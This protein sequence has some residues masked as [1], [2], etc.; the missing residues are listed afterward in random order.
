MSEIQEN[1]ISESENNENTKV[2][3]EFQGEDEEERENVP[4]ASTAAEDVEKM[5]HEGVEEIVSNEN[6][7]GF[8]GII[9]GFDTDTKPTLTNVS[10]ENIS[11]VVEEDPGFQSKPTDSVSLKSP[12]AVWMVEKNVSPKVMNTI[13]WKDIKRT[14]C[15]FGGILFLLLSLNC[16]PLISVVTTFAL[17]FLCVCF[18][19]HI[20]MTVF[21]VVQKT[22]AE[23]PFKNL[24]EQNIEIPE[25]VVSQLST[26]ICKFINAEI[27]CCQRL[28]LIENL[29]ES[30]KF[31]ITLWLVSYVS[32]WFSLLTMIIL[33]V[34]TLFTVPKLYEEKQTEIDRCFCVVK[35]KLCDVTK[36]LE[37][38]VPEKF[39][40]YLC[41]DKKE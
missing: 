36:Q 15:I 35:G 34:I 37:Q 11:S 4:T 18:L 30:V 21:N 8:R 3:D 39:K 10:T 38:K 22:T 31:G 24:L 9:D 17:G 29:F 13:Y 26:C 7:D 40:K 28:F 23:H 14:G 12:L 25:E 32:C 2:H 20:G 41:K 19:Y 1:V 5:A 33:S 27:K 16:Y 6:E